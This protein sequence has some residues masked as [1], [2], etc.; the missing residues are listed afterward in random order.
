[1]NKSLTKKMSFKKSQHKNHY[2]M[3]KVGSVYRALGPISL[4]QFEVSEELNKHN[5]HY[6]YIE[7]GETFLMLSFTEDKETCKALPTISFQILSGTR[8]GWCC[9]YTN[10]KRFEEV[11]K[12]KDEEEEGFC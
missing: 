8:I 6:D 2:Q 1:M 4:W 12:E 3:V 7:Q 10:E 11:T 9:C 5:E